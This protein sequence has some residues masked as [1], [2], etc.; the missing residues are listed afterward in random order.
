MFP[1]LPQ[2]IE[3]KIHLIV[4]ESNYI[5]C[6]NQLLEVVK[7]LN[8]RYSWNHYSSHIETLEAS[9]LYNCRNIQIYKYQPSKNC[10]HE[11]VYENWHEEYNYMNQLL[12]F[13]YDKRQRKFELREYLKKN[14]IFCKNTA[15]RKQLLKVILD[16]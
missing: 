3:D 6:L 10:T 11:C 14:R 13:L 16:L 7:K 15:T 9:K 5:P 4:H 8:R 1:Q 12:H 2:E